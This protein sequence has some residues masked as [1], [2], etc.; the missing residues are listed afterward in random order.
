MYSESLETRM[1]SGSTAS[2]TILNATLPYPP[3]VNVGS[4]QAKGAM[5]KMERLHPVQEL[6]ELWKIPSTDLTLQSHYPDPSNAQVVLNA[7]VT[8]I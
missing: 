7:N 3:A 4:D 1:F 2:S 5:G 6:V 8:R